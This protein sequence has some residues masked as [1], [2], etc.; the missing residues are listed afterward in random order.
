MAPPPAPVYVQLRRSTVVGSGGESVVDNYRTSYGTFLRCGRG[1][2]CLPRH[3]LPRICRQ[4]NALFANDAKTAHACA[5]AAPRPAPPR[6][7]PLRPCRRHQDEVVSRLEERV[8]AW[9]KLPISHQEDIQVAEWQQ[10]RQRQ[11]QRQI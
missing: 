10:Q 6:P 5:P 9:V 3:C 2:V 4:C 7:A 1:V 11:R 8:A